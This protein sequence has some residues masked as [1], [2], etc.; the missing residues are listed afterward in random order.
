[1]EVFDNWL[2]QPEENKKDVSKQKQHLK[3]HSNNNN[4]EVLKG[5]GTFKQLP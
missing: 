2:Y 4:N 1:M 3:I 5:L